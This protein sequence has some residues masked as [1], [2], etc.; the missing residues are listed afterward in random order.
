MTWKLLGG[1]SQGFEHM[2]L[3]KLTNEEKLFLLE[4]ALVQA[5]HTVQ[6]LHNCLSHPAVKDEGQGGFLGYVYVYPEQTL[7]HLKEW[8]KLAPIPL[9][10]CHSRQMPGCEACKEAHIRRVRRG[11]IL[12]KTEDADVNR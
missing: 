9:L 1:Q 11:Q 12:N 6:F 5:Q 2:D 4:D 7:Q 10:C 3:T 8:E